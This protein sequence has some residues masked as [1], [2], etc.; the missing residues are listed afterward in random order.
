MNREAIESYRAPIDGMR[1]LR[2]PGRLRRLK[3]PLPADPPSDGPPAACFL[4]HPERDRFDLGP[5]PR[6]G[7]GQHVVGN[8]HPFAARA[9]LVA[10]AGEAHHLATPATLEPARLAEWLEWPG[11]GAFSAAFELAP[12]ATAAFVNVGRGAAQ[13]RR[14]PH[15]QVVSFDAAAGALLE[16]DPTEIAD[17]LASAEVEGRQLALQD[18]VRVVVPK[19]PSQTAELWLPLPAQGSEPDAWQRAA[20]ALATVCRAAERSISGNYNLVWRTAAPPLLR[21]VP[22]GLSERAGLELAAP[23]LLAGVVAVSVR[24]SF[25]LWAAALEAAP[26]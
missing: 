6:A 5:C 26:S 10:P 21:I 17:D 20:H 11:S 25:L 19:R 12:G 24:E 8:A 22:R 18:G 13:S 15:L 16:D 4:C 9:L 23:A 7:G 1:S 14:H 3:L 2:I